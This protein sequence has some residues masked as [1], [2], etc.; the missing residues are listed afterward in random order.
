MKKFLITTFFITLLSLNLLAYNTYGF[1]IEDDTYI[2]NTKRDLLVLMLA[3]KEEI[4]EIEISK[5]NYIY[6]ILNNNSK[7]LYDDKKEKNRDSKVSNS[8]V[9]DTLE[10]IYPLESIDKV[11][12]GIDPGRSRCYSLLNGLYGGNRKEVEKNLSSISTLCGNI[13]FN[14]NARAGEALK[15]ALNEAKELANNKNKINNFIF[16]ISGGYNYRVIQDTGRLSPH[17]YAI[18][19]D[20]NR[21]NSDYWKWV[22]KSKG[23]KRIEEYPKELVK[24]FEDNGFIWGGKWEHFDILHFEYRP[25]IILKSK[26]FGN[27]SNINEG[28]WYDGVPINAETEELINIIDSKI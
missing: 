6:L 25:E 13:T 5:D 18:A 12:E 2:N 22:D 21:N 11:L 27:S 7:I 16:P 15:K 23:S 8:D 28:N 4:K 19:I 10:E 1:I 24:I 17:A 20:L 14:K 26:Y 9:Q 3:Y